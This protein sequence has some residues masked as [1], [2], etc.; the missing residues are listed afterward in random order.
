MPGGLA[1]DNFVFTPF[2]SV[3]ADAAALDVKPQTGVS[4]YI[5]T[6]DSGLARA[7]PTVGLEYRYPFISV[8]SWGTQTVEPIAQV[9]ARPNEPQI[10]KWPNEDAQSFTFDDSNLALRRWNLN[11]VRLPIPPPSRS[12]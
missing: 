11:P 4:N 5:D 3:R 6:G 8:S 9:I 1:P 12:L 7:M 10:G 2:V